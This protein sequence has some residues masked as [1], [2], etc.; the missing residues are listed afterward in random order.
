M[1]NVCVG[2]AYG[3]CKFEMMKDTIN[4]NDKNGI[5]WGNSGKR[6][7]LWCTG[8]GYALG[9]CLSGGNNHGWEHEIPNCQQCHLSD[10]VGILVNN[11]SIIS[12][13]V[14]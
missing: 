3:S 6:K 11:K 10:E 14:L 7:S 1:L 5:V 13:S 9:E 12:G 2:V 8:V 4:M